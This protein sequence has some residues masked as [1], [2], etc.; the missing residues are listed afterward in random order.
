LTSLRSSKVT[1]CKTGITRRLASNTAS[2]FSAMPS[3][4]MLLIS[5]GVTSTIPTRELRSPLS[6]SRIINEP[7]GRSSSLNHTEA[8]FVFRWPYSSAALPL[9]SAQAWHRKR[10]RRS[11]SSAT[12]WGCT[13]PSCPPWCDERCHHHGYPRNR[14]WPTRPRTTRTSAGCT[15]STRSTRSR[16]VR[17]GCCTQDSGRLRPRIG[18]PELGLCIAPCAQRLGAITPWL[19]DCPGSPWPDHDRRGDLRRCSVDLGPARA[20]HRRRYACSAGRVVRREFLIGRWLKD[21]YPLVEFLSPDRPGSPAALQIALD[22]PPP[23]LIRMCRRKPELDG[24]ADRPC[25]VPQR[26]TLCP[27][28]GSPLDDDVVSIAEQ[29]E[30]ELQLE[31]FDLGAHRRIPKVDPRD[32]HPVVR[33]HADSRHRSGKLSCQA[34]LAAAGQA[35]DDDETPWRS[36]PIRIH[37]HIVPPAAA[38]GLLCPRH[39]RRSGQ[40][41]SPRRPTHETTDVR[42]PAHDQVAARNSRTTATASWRDRASASASPSLRNAA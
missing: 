2:S 1:P 23:K 33:A 21:A 4:V 42:G 11:R 14:P 40:C 35:G 22:D 5:A 6:I 16:S 41:R 15:R 28:P 10:S 34:R 27:G 12:H 8:P 19:I 31:S 29:V 3:S 26:V 13:T 24:G 18:G 38:A 39:S 32:H 17:N 7:R 30:S 36:I 9:R 37:G 25:R 20:E